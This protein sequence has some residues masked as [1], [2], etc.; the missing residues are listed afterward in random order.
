ML[1]VK[2]TW[3]NANPQTIANRLAVKLGRPASDAE[4]VA[5]VRRILREG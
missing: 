3:A 4:L 5:E 2:I 1:Q